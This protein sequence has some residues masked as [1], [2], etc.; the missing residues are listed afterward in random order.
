MVLF[1]TCGG[2]PGKH[3]L[4]AEIKVVDDGVQSIERWIEKRFSAG[5]VCGDPG[6]R[7]NRP[8]WQGYFMYPL[9]WQELACE[10]VVIA[11]QGGHL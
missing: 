8:N 6:K 2:K 10:F 5:K 4:V 3:P 11:A 1:Q 7:P 9:L